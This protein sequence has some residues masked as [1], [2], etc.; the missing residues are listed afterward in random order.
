M[1]SRII[2]AVVLLAL[3]GAT[4]AQAQTVRYIHTDALGTPVAVTNASRTVIEISEYEPYGQVINGAVKAGPGYTGHVMDVST[5]L[6]YM[7][8]RYYDPNLGRF[9][10][11]DPVTA[12]SSTGAN[13]NRYWYAANNPYK[14]TDPDGRAHDVFWVNENTVTV[15]IPFAISDPTGTAKFTSPQVSAAIQDKFSGSI[16][17]DGVQVQVNAV[18]LPVELNS[19]TNNSEHVNVIDVNRNTKR[20]STNR[21]GGNRIDLRG[22]AGA[23]VVAHELGHAAGAG[24]QYPTGVDASGQRIPA[25]AQGTTGNVMGDMTGKANAQTLREV[26]TAPSATRTCAGGVQNGACP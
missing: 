16:A 9:L 15:V 21:I 24:D 4:A 22:S 18:G 23:D 17:I 1:I 14:F 11:V 26:V 3:Y 12:N 20:S 7:Q 2:F 19:R 6:A 8:Q 5:G 25:T 13:F 10:S